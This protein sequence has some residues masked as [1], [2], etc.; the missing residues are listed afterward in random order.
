MKNTGILIGFVPLVVFGILAGNS[1]SGMILASGAALIATV[2]VSYSDLRKGMILSWTNLV[3]F[4]GLLLMI[5]PW[6]LTGLIPWTGVIIYAVLAGV[7][8]GSILA[9]IP[10]TLQYAREM[11]APA[12]WENPAFLR[13]NLLMTG[14]W[15]TLFVIN[16]GL[17]YL[18]LA[19]P[20]IPGRIAMILTYAVLVSGILFTLWYP[21]YIQKKHSA[22]AGTDRG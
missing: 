14:T 2:I 17:S 7:T 15:G 19:G 16:L 9:G 20:V 4:G 3:L 1:V 10:F 6:G 18:V 13:V 22:C 21:R 8:F 12:L 5:G 11:V